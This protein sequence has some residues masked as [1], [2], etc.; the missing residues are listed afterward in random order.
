MLGTRD[1]SEDRESQEPLH[2]PGLQD[3]ARAEIG[4]RR[5]DDRQGQRGQHPAGQRAGSSASRGRFG[6][7]AG[8]DD[9]VAVLEGRPGGVQLDPGAVDALEERV[10]LLHR[11]AE[12]GAGVLP[13]T[14]SLRGVRPRPGRPRSP[15]RWRR[16]LL[17]LR[18]RP[19]PAR[20]RPAALAPPCGARRAGAS[21]PGA[22][23]CSAGA[24]GHRGVGV[25][26]DA[27]SAAPARPAARPGGAAGT[28]PAR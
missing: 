9:A 15:G 3:P 18:V 19:E 28:P 14:S 4:Q 27:S 22:R 23:R 12:P 13:R 17:R 26:V 20:T 8:P 25:G 16:A 10:V 24:S 2:L 6:K 1:L 7:M 21:P 5:G 11:E